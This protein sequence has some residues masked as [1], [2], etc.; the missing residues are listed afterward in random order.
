MCAS[1]KV[2][3]LLRL[4]GPDVRQLRLLHWQVPILYS[5]KG[6]RKLILDVST[7][8]P[9]HNPI[10]VASLAA[11]PRLQQLSLYGRVGTRVGGVEELEQLRC[12][13][14]ADVVPLGGLPSCHLTAL[15]L[16]IGTGSLPALKESLQT[17]KGR[18]QTAHLHMALYDELMDK[19]CLINS[20]ADVQELH[21]SLNS[22]NQTRCRWCP[23]FFQRLQVLHISLV[24]VCSGLQPA[25]DFGA[26]SLAEFHICVA[27]SRNV[28][29]QDI[30]NV[31]ADVVHLQLLQMVSGQERCS[32][33][34]ASWTIA[35][36][37]VQYKKPPGCAGP[38]PLYV[39]DAVGAL[40]CTQGSP[41]VLRIN[42]MS[43]LR[44][45]ACAAKD[46]QLEAALQQS[47]AFDPSE[48][49]SSY[50]DSDECD[51]DEYDSDEWDSDADILSEVSED[52]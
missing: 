37:N 43:P 1:D 20:L 39:T 46:G 15:H 50:S 51:S 30:V 34:C 16:N 22:Y 11:Y 21:L 2:G 8:R 23:G 24:K 52:A 31:Q 45:A 12:L 27:V 28:C 40:M 42:G 18:L 13:E 33:E 47:L 41:I 32:L 5:F 35:Q 3:H 29:L 25:W 9:G 10:S 44:A 38:F 7:V 4:T 17:F 49:Y 6:V 26:C 36:A 14:L 19:L 48:D